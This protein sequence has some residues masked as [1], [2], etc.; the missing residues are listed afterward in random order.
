MSKQWFF[1][2][3]LFGG[4]TYLWSWVVNILLIAIRM[5]LDDWAK[6]VIALVLG[7]FTAMLVVA[8]LQAEN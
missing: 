7:L 1:T 5:V 6:I 3:A 8:C 4:F 2:M